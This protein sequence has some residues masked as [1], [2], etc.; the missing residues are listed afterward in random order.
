MSEDLCPNC[1]KDTL[2]FKSS[3]I[4]SGKGKDFVEWGYYFCKNCGWKSDLHELSDKPASK[5]KAIWL[6]QHFDK[7]NQRLFVWV[8]SGEISQQNYIFYGQ[9]VFDKGKVFASTNKEV[10]VKK[11]EEDPDRKP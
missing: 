11:L 3:A 4:Q 2:K 5:K 9:F 10:F 8:Y 6:H 7:V 1:K